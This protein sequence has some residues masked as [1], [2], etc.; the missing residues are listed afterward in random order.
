MVLEKEIG[1]QLASRLDGV[2]E[3]ATLKLN[4][5]VQAMK[6]Q[7]V[8]VMNL[9][10]GEPDFWV[11]EAAKN[12]VI[13]AVHS[14][15][16]KYTPV[17]GIPLLREEVARKTNQQQK[18]LSSISPWKASSVVITNGGKQALFNAFM[19]VLNP[20]DE[21]LI[22]SPYWLSY[23]EMVKLAGGIPK[24]IPT[25]PST[26][27]KLT[28]EQLS[29][30]LGPKVKS[31]I[32]NS[33]SNPTG[34]LY[35]K[36]EYRALGKVLAAFSH[37]KSLWILSDEIYDRIILGHTP[38]CSFLD[39]NPELAEQT[40]TINGVSKSAAM[41]GWRLGW[42][43]ASE[44]VTQAMTTLQGQSTSGVNALVQWASLAALKIPE[45]EFLSQ[46][47]SFRKRRDLLLESLKKARKLDFCAPDGAFY[48]FVGI[49][50]YLKPGEDSIGFA[51]RVLEE[52]QV[53][54]VPGAPFGE[55]EY[56]RLSFATDERSI[57][58]GCKRLV[59]YIDSI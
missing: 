25:S 45:T 54:V 13:D 7:G 23:P 14:N 58:E 51:Q 16:S 3:S 38:F 33:P 57:L 52:A 43:V 15:Q 24:F 34:A 6:A 40:I 18:S 42:S 4:A 22:P 2:S 46:V 56:V 8:D 11:P 20:G 32:F 47:D 17:A 10:A 50:K 53:A 5:T 59:N 55:P 28:P 35:S 26:G 21:V 1:L 48:V 31:I 9:T 36:E 41:T 37:V 12:A 30:S 29:A 49:S 39:A 27:F 44:R 19:A